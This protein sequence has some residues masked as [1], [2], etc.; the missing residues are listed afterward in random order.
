M[1]R[2]RDDS[3]GSNYYKEVSQTHWEVAVQ[4]HEWAPALALHIRVYL[5]IINRVT[6]VNFYR[7]CL[8]LGVLHNNK[9]TV[10]PNNEASL[11]V[12]ELRSRGD[13]LE[14]KGPIN[15]AATTPSS[16]PR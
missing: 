12:C 10:L 1:Q 15:R 13:L 16:N 14:W 3:E 7:N 4:L 5:T 2:Q 8:Y 6:I 11:C 9:L